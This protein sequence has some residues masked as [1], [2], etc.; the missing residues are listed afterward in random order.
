[1]RWYQSEADIRETLRN[2]PEGLSETY[3]RILAKLGRKSATTITMA[4]RIF[5]WVVCARRSLF[6]DELKEAIAFQRTINRGV[7]GRSRQIQMANA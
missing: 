7:K 6:I 3:L 2:L 5:K 1:M 4:E